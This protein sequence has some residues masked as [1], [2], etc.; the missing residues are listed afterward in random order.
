MRELLNNEVFKESDEQCAAGAKCAAKF[1]ER[2]LDLGG[3]VGDHRE[4]GE[5]TASS[6]SSGTSSALSD[7]VAKS[8]PG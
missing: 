3:L 1:L 8:I 5:R 6:D 2:E 4:P 7:P